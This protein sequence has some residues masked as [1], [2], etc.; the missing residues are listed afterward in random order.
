MMVGALWELVVYLPNTKAL[1]GLVPGSDKELQ[2][3]LT[4]SL[5]SYLTTDKQDG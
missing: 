5:M 1:K 4:R 2:Q 3:E